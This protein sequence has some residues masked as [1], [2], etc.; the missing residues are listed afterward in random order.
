M[1][2]LTCNSFHKILEREH[3]RK[4]CK[5][6]KN[7]KEKKKKKKNTHTHTK[8][9]HYIFQ[10]NRNGKNGASNLVERPSIYWIIRGCHKNKLWINFSG[11]L[12][13]FVKMSYGRCH[14]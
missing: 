13:R 3:E 6:K 1:S 8:E 12:K 10:P 9:K 2:S 11:N 14:N 5:E 4:K 7:V